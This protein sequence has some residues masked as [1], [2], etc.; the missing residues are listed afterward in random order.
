MT[1]GLSLTVVQ[2]G[3]GNPKVVHP[4]GSQRGSQ[5][6]RPA[7]IANGFQERQWFTP[8]HRCYLP[9]RH[10]EWIA[11]QDHSAH[12]PRLGRGGWLTASVMTLFPLGFAGPRLLRGDFVRSGA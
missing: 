8:R 6:P 7:G 11:K 3:P 1:S 2:A 10:S 5:P 9:R 12:I 4:C